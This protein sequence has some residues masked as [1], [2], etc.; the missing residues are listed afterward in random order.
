MKSEA[1]RS[2]VAVALLAAL[3]L[4]PYVQTAG[5]DFVD[6][7]DSVYVTANSQVRAGVSAAGVVWAFSAQGHEANWHPLTW[8][9]LM[10]D[11]TLFGV[12]PGWMHLENAFL[13]AAAAVLLLIL[14]RRLTGRLDAAFAAAALWALHPLRVECVAWISQRKDLLGTL[15]GLAAMLCHVAVLRAVPSRSA[16]GAPTGRSAGWQA[17]SLAFF[18]LGFMAKPTVVTFPLLA[19]A[20]EYTALGRVNWRQYALPF[21]AMAAGMAITV[22]A[23]ATGGA[24]DADAPLLLRV[25]NAAVSLAVYL[26]QTFVPAGLAVVY[27]LRWPSL[28]ALAAGLAVTA[29][30]AA[31]VWRAGFS[32]AARARGPAGLDGANARSLLP[33]AA[34]VAWF[35]VALSPMVGL[36]QVGQQAHADRYTGWPSI[37]L[38][39][40]AAWA[41]ARVGRGF[42]VAAGSAVGTAVLLLGWGSWRQTALWHNTRILFSHACDV[43]PGNHVARGVLGWND[44]M[45]GRMEEGIR[46]FRQ[47]RLFSD[48]SKYM[49]GLCWGLVRRGCLDEAER[50]AREVW[51]RDPSD[52]NAHLV[53]AQ[54]AWRRQAPGAEQQF[55]R[56]LEENPG[57]ATAWWEFGLFLAVRERLSE[58]MDAWQRA[59]AI[60]PSLDLGA[61]LR[62]VRELR[63]SGNAGS[64]AR[65]I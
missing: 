8:L 53:F 36:V 39:L 23:Q 50:A 3:A 1:K 10:L 56:F 26:R 62:E 58:A 57:F 31:V 25:G 19:V 51:S 14:L 47:A 12:S 21:W 65:E 2:A 54:V 45:R 15:F 28:A 5:F 48:D 59:W 38:A 55:R 30:L 22:H 11:V 40:A 46:H 20:V 7:D 16:A 35:L 60:N 17:S 41:L 64:V 34:G 6:Y 18:A 13:H 29:G 52:P 24:I 63:S 27:P 9:S 32:R 42:R 61:W 4:A 37:G 43:V 33:Y 44:Y 49:R